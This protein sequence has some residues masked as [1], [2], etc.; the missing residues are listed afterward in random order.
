VR[1]VRLLCVVRLPLTDR[2]EKLTRIAI[3][4]EDKCKPKKCRQEC[5]KSCPVV[6]MGKLCIEVDPTSKVRCAAPT[7]SRCVNQCIS[8][9]CQRRES[10][11]QAGRQRLGCPVFFFLFC[12]VAAFFFFFFFVVGC[13]VPRTASSAHPRAYGQISFISE[14]LCIGCGICVKKCPL[15]AISIINLPSD[16]S[17]DTTHRYGC[18]RNPACLF[19]EALIVWSN[20]RPTVDLGRGFWA[21][22]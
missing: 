5:K 3:V 22:Y 10:S 9:I 1:H 2:A 6:R 13:V 4:S 8:V 19:L 7:V 18:A 20:C 15:E 17:K 11:W 16:L 12:W 14:V 21:E